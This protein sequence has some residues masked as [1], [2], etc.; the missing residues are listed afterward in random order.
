MAAAAA[1]GEGA[2][3]HGEL[4]VV[5]GQQ[6]EAGPCAGMRRAV[7][8]ALGPGGEKAAKAKAHPAERGGAEQHAPL[9][10]QIVFHHEILSGVRLNGRPNRRSG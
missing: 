7:A 2:V 10:H 6:V 4:D 5:A 3:R 1:D 8:A 9:Q